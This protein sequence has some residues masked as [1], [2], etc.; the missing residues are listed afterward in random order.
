MELKR[1]LEAF[2]AMGKTYNDEDTFDIFKNPNQYEV[3]QALKGTEDYP[4]IIDLPT[5]RALRGF[6]N[7]KDLYIWGAANAV[8]DTVYH[9]LAYSENIE[10]GKNIDFYEVIPLWLFLDE[11]FQVVEVR[12]S[13]TAIESPYSK[14]I[15]KKTWSVSPEIFIKYVRPNKNLKAISAPKVKW[16]TKLGD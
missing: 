16:S 8:H 10:I 14:Y 12:V 4:W 9:T 15:N 2:V 3:R 6:I 5:H 7:D 11:G 13:P 1:L